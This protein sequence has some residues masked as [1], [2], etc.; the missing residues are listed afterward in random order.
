[1]SEF[2]FASFKNERERKFP[3][4]RKKSIHG[5]RGVHEGPVEAHETSGS[6]DA[7]ARGCGRKCRVCLPLPSSCIHAFGDSLNTLK[8][9]LLVSA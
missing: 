7:S 6:V 5:G 2:S 8:L 3:N 1:M 9:Q 4:P